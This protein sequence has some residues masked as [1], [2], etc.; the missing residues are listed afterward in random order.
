MYSCTCSNQTCDWLR[1]L[2]GIFGGLLSRS[3]TLTT[4]SVLWAVCCGALT[5]S[6]PRCH[7]ASE[8]FRRTRPL[9]KP[10]SATSAIHKRQPLSLSPSLLS[11]PSPTTAL[12][13]HTPSFHSLYLPPSYFLIFLKI[14]TPFF[15]HSFSS[16]LPFFSLLVLFRL[17]QELP[18]SV[19]PLIWLFYLFFCSFFCLS[20]QIV[21]HIQWKKKTPQPAMCSNGR[22]S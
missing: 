21:I 5:S 2:G 15:V 8:G 13:S 16:V 18:L 22:A 9:P 20:V 12:H 19:T 10:H 11:R 6:S 3:C 4:L 7:P 14:S 1:F 17:Q